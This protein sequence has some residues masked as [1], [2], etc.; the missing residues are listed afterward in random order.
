[1]EVLAGTGAGQR[2]ELDAF[3]HA[4][5]HW[6][7]L[8]VFD[9]RLGEVVEQRLRHQE[10]LGANATLAVVE[11][12]R[13]H[14]E[15]HGL[16]KIGVL[17]NDEWIG[18]AE[19]QP[20][21]LSDSGRFLRNG[22]AGADAAGDGDGPHPRI[23]DDGRTRLNRDCKVHI[24]SFGATGVAHQ[25]LQ[26]LGTALDRFGVLDESGIADKGCGVEEAQHLPEGYVPRRNGEDRPYRFIY[27]LRR[28]AGDRLWLEISFTRF[29]EVA[30]V[31]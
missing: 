21:S 9:K 16:R 22:A 20:R 13:R 8:G 31:P 19:F 18:T 28:Y 23:G 1:M 11:V 5:A 29:G 24:Q 3:L 2:A 17:Q 7:R 6:K 4:I 15:L 26:R 27:D 25:G 10:T 14:G 30:G 12:A